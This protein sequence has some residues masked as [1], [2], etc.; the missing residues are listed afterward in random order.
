MIS[1]GLGIPL[2]QD[3]NGTLLMN[4]VTE[5]SALRK[6]GFKHGISVNKLVTITQTIGLCTLRLRT[7]TSGLQEVSHGNVAATTSASNA[8][9]LAFPV[10]QN[11]QD[12]FST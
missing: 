11:N 4:D 7:G 3:P 1:L 9:S 10:L 2:V 6:F 12:V 5:D 8:K